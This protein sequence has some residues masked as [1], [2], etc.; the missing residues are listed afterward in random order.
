MATIPCLDCSRPIP[1][2]PG[3]TGRCPEC[4]RE[5]QRR[6]DARRGTPAERGYD[7][8]WRRMRKLVLDRDGWICHWCGR[9]AISVDH[10]QPLARGGAR[11]D[12]FNVVACCRSQL[13]TWRWGA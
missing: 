6:R 8:R 2:R 3:K 5:E 4:S 9:P 13:A 11:L 12:T 7:Q 1:K 10:V